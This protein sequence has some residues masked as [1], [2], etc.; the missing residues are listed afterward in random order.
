MHNTVSET[1]K[2]IGGQTEA[3]NLIPI[4][5]VGKLKVLINVSAV[6]VHRDSPIRQ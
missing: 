2:P 3:R 6:P 1:S 5:A 4:L